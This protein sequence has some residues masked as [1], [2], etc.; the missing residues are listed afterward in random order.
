MSGA[1][2]ET[3]GRRVLALVL[4]DLLVELAL[5]QRLAMTVE[6]HA[7]AHKPL[8]VVL[9]NEP[10]KAAPQQ[11]SLNVAGKPLALEKEMLA[12]E[13]LAAVSREAERFGVRARQTIDEASAHVS[14]LV[15][16][17]VKQVAVEKALGGL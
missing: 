12:S 16:V 9:V 3:R 11:L 6:L 14:Q 5:R 17:K 1:S 7:D 15:V 4:P 10:E 2:P 13:P 8:G